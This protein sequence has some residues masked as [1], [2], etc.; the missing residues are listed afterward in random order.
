MSPSKVSSD[1]AWGVTIGAAGAILLPRV[2][3]TLLS[4]SKSGRTSNGRVLLTSVLD[5][6]EKRWGKSNSDGSKTDPTSLSS[7]CIKYRD[8]VELRKELEAAGSLAI[9]DV[10][11]DQSPT[12]DQD[13]YKMLRKFSEFSVNTS[14]PLFVNQLFGTLDRA[15]LAADFMAAADNTSNY[16]YEAAPVYSMVEV[17]VLTALCKQVGWDYE[18]EC[19]G[20]MLPGGS[21]SNVMGMHC[22]RHSKFPETLKEGNAAMGKKPMAFVAAEAHYSFLKCSGLLGLGRESIVKVECDDSGAMSVPHLRKA[23]EKCKKEGGTPFFIGCTAGSTVRGTFDPFE[24]VAKVGKEY[25]CWVHV[26]GAWGGSAIMSDRQDM[27]DL[28]KGVSS[29]DSFTFNPH[30]MLGAPLQTTCF[31]CRRKDFMLSVNSSKAGYLFDTRKA[32]A[33]LDIGDK[34]FMCGRKVDAI[35]FW[36]LWR[37]RGRDGLA[38][39]VNRNVDNL[40]AFAEKIKA[41]PSFMLACDPWAFNL[42]FFF[43]PKRIKKLLDDANI[44]LDGS[45]YKIPDD[46]SD[47][48]DKVSV[49]LKLAMQ[50]AG[51]ALVPYQ[52][53]SNQKAQC[54]RVVVAGVKDMNDEVTTAMMNLMIKHGDDM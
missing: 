45:T 50:K 26:D 16:T 10:G 36:A 23:L 40:K 25:G 37:Y 44:P 22:A 34:T 53:L 2:L 18:K 6:I 11:M 4:L 35:K 48:I 47:E 42:N 38:A 14:H 27:K 20:M 1:L 32:N 8:P 49:A 43:I 30:K 17:E 46:I 15:S 33:H 51:K 12:A 54:F 9:A 21:V 13:M 28:M 52:P 24:E 39:R 3:E 5:D 29:C 7:S 19:D 31:I 41:H